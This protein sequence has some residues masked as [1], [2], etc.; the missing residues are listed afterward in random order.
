MNKKLLIILL[1][2][3][4]ISITGCAWVGKQTSKNP[5]QD[6]NMICEQIKHKML[7]E[8]NGQDLDHNISNKFIHNAQLHSQYKK[9]GCDKK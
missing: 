4:T 3:A 8:K 2:I 5:P 1:A 7:F 6:K 9:F